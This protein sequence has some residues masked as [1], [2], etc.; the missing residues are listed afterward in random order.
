MMDVMS[1]EERREL[2]E[3]AKQRYEKLKEEYN[4]QSFMLPAVRTKDGAPLSDAAPQLER[5]KV[6]KKERMEAELDELE[7]IIEQLS[8]PNILI[9][10]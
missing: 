4:H 3:A 5:F 1:D 2:L 8:K 10:N 9:A 6:V 7:K